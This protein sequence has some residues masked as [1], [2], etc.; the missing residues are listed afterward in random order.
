MQGI[1]NNIRACSLREL[2]PIQAK[3]SI[4]TW[5]KNRLIAAQ[6]APDIKQYT[7]SVSL[8]LPHRRI[9]ID[10]ANVT[11]KK[12]AILQ[13]KSEAAHIPHCYAGFSIASN[14]SVCPTLRGPANIEKMRERL[15]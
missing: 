6:S 7:S 10:D 1:S 9:D 8:R 4:D 3:I 11:R 13:G 14:T 2:R 5:G 15:S 12:P